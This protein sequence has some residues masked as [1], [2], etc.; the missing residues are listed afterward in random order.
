MDPLTQSLLGG[1]AAHATCARWLGRRAFLAGLVGGGL[2]DVDIFWTG[3]GDPAVP[4]ELHRHFTHALVF[5]P[6][7]ALAAACLLLPWRWCRERFRLVYL[8]CLVGYA[9][10]A[11]LDLCTSYGTVCWWPWSSDRVGWDLIAILDPVFTGLLLAGAGLGALRRR[12]RW[13]A[14]ALVLCVLHLGL[15]YVQRERAQ[16]AQ[17]VVA[18]GRG[19]VIE[20]GRVMPTLGNLLVWRSV[21]IHGGQLVADTLRLPL[22][23]EPGVR[24]GGS[25]PHVDL[26]RLP[27]ADT[28]REHILEVFGEFADGYVAWLPDR[29]T[30]LGD[31]RYSIGGDLRPIWGVDLAKPAWVT[32]HDERRA[33][34]R[35]FWA[36]LTDSSRFVPLE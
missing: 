9:T 1:V 24:P 15:G 11:P 14:A 32:F 21:Y 28:R 19:Q 16:A 35:T 23:G 31:L 27:V 10:H 20:R 30:V 12:P 2:A 33:A 18:E 13:S 7:G 6:V 26:T 8:A 36:D 17:Q 4:F 25:L 34:A 3:L 5:I 22:G 29:P